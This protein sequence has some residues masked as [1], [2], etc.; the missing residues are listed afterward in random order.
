MAADNIFYATN[1]MRS[2]VSSLKKK[3]SNLKVQIEQFDAEIQKVEG[4]FDNIL[5]QAEIYKSKVEREMGREVRR[6]EKELALASREV[7]SES[8]SEASTL[9]LR[10]ASTV[11]V[12]ETIL[13]HMCG[14]A[15]DFRLASQAFLFPAVYERVMKGEE[16]AYY[17]EKIP[18]SAHLIIKRGQ[19]HISWLR[20]E[21]ETHLTDPQT[22][23]LSIAYIAEWWRNDALPLLYGA[24]DEQWDIDLPLTL[25]EM[26][27]W[28]DS[29]AERP[30]LFSPVFDA[31]EVYRKNKDLIYEPSG[32]REFEFKH[33]SFNE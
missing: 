18:D 14:N 27:A 13:R 15:D 7:K 19:E 11:A 4:K 6:L 26:L 25:T 10:I 17:M 20:S 8:L 22:W 31:Y 3:L 9:D 2:S 28:R 5:T 16:E 24:R 23:E 30:L 21:Y 12:F 33:F 29:P 1:S 32:I